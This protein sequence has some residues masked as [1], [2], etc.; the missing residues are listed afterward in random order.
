MQ[1]VPKFALRRLRIAEGVAEAHL[2]ADVLTA[3]AEQNL[4]DHER[5]DVMKHLAGCRECREVISIALPEA[6]LPATSAVRATSRGVLDGPVLRWGVLAAGILIVA[7]VGVVIVQHQHPIPNVASLQKNTNSA[8]SDRLPPAEPSLKN[9]VSQDGSAMR[10][11]GVGAYSSPQQGSGNPGN[12]TESNP[13]RQRAPIA[14]RARQIETELTAQNIPPSLIHN[15]SSVQNSKDPASQTTTGSGSATT[16]QI[17]R[18]IVTP[19]GALQRSMDAGK[20]WENVNPVL[21]APLPDGTD[22]QLVFHVV[23]SKGLEVWAA[24]SGGLLFAST[25]GGNRWSLI[26]PSSDNATLTGDVTRIEFTDQRKKVTSST[27]ELWVTSDDGVNW[28]K[29]Q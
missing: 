25:D 12:V 15:H 2:D 19:S 10:A 27:G 1:S 29:W 4:A 20:S 3:F 22:S 7:S 21:D 16:I 13:A 8:Q 23:A 9:S 24:C 6:E 14:L 18:W 11:A 5:A 26:T 17:P 28:Q